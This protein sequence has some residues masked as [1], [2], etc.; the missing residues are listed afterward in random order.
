MIRLTMTPLPSVN[1]LERRAILR[2]GLAVV[3]SSPGVR[4]ARVIWTEGYRG[5]LGG[6]H[7]DSRG[8][9]M[10]DSGIPILFVDTSSLRRAGFRNSDFQKL[11]LRSKDRTIRI[12]VSAI[13]WEEWRTH[14]RDKE[15]EKVRN[16]K[17]QFEV[18]KANALSN[19]ILGR[20]PPPALA[21][22]DDA[23]SRIANRYALE[24]R[25]AP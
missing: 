2:P 22:W 25:G 18:L 16:V 15:C 20:L 19:R 23:D 6:V 3:D 5:N 10:P 11:L 14:M 4:G 9:C 13:S 21:V 12:V 24:L 17:S 7:V 8:V 1:N